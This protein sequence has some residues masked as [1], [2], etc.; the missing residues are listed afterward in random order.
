MNTWRR[1]L[2]R[3]QN[4]ISLVLVSVFFLTAL[5]APVLAPPDN[6]ADPSPYRVVGR[7]TDRTPHPPS[8]DAPLGTTVGQFSI[9]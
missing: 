3:P 1:F 7:L 4:L 8:P 5:L 2:Q 9:Y 6:P